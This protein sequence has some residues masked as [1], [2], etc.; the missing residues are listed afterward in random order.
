[1]TTISTARAK[2]FCTGSKLL[3]ALCV[4]LRRALPRVRFAG[5]FC[6]HDQ[7]FNVNDLHTFVDGSI[8]V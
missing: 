6:M 8:T 5:N 1:M 2:T 7:R 4:I 3:Y